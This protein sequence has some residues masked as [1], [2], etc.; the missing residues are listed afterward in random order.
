MICEYNAEQGERGLAMAAQQC[1]PVT[2]NQHGLPMVAGMRADLFSKHGHREVLGHRGRV[3]VKE[4]GH[5]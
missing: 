4:V 1:L 3:A 2:K 5:G